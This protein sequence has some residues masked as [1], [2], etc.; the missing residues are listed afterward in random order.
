MKALIVVIVNAFKSEIFNVRYASFEAITKQKYSLP[1]Q[2][3]G[4][5]GSIFASALDPRPSVTYVG[6]RQVFA[7]ETGL[8]RGLQL[9]AAGW[10]EIS[11]SILKQ[12]GLEESIQPAIELV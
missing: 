10:D 12:F 4:S 5:I 2:H 11:G 9:L 3:S 6:R 7:P 1:R 8:N